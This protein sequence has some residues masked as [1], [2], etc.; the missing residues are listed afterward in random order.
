MG[1]WFTKGYEILTATYHQVGRIFCYHHVAFFF[2][3]KLKIIYKVIACML[4][5]ILVQT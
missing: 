1:A 4:S 2:F 3:F 5:C